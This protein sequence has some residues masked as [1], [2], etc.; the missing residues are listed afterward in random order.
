MNHQD[1]VNLIKGRIGKPGGIWADFGSETGAFTFALAELIGPTGQIISVD[2]DTDKGNR[3][4][5]HPISFQTWQTI[6]RDAGCA[7]T[8]LL[9][10]RPS[11]F[12]GKIY[13]AMSLSQKQ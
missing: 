1:H 13:A 2:K 6:A 8:T 12:L 9:A 7:N 5:P 4:V 11:R 3:W 10:S